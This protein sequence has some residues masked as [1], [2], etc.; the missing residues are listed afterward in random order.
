MYTLQLVD[1]HVHWDRLPEKEWEGI[2]DRARRAG[3]V[4]AVAVGT[5]AASCTTLLRAKKRFPDFLDISL[6]YHPEQAVRWDEVETVLRQIREHRD[7]LAGV[8]E[9]G[10]PWYSLSEEKRSDPSDPDH[11]GALERL[12]RTAV[13]LDLPVLLHAV[14][15]RA[16][17]MFRILQAHGVRK[18]VFHWLKAPEKTVDKIAGAGYLISVTPEVCYRSRDRELAKRVP[19]SQIL[20]ETDAP[21]RYRGPFRNRSA[22]PAW[23]RRT[24]EALSQIKRVSFLQVSEQTTANAARLFG[25]PK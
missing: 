7:L 4:K 5:D 21:W 1:T 19:V 12:M 25:W 11:K 10:L 22:E 18:A 24:A 6:G 8:G 16:E 14:H 23:V 3:V 2:V 17:E 13:E 15:D 9:V 20:L